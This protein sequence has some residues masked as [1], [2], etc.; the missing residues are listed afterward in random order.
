[1]SIRYDYLESLEKGD[2]SV[3]PPAVYVRGFIR[4]YAGFLGMDAQQLVRIYNHELSYMLED[5][6]KVKQKKQKDDSGWKARLSIT[7]HILTLACSFC[8]IAVLGYYFMHQINSFNSKPYLFIESPSANGVV[9]EKE[10]WISG[11][12]EE[13]AVLRINGQEISVGAGG[14][15]KEK[16]TLAEGRNTLVV[17]AENRF[18][19]IERREINIIYEAPPQEKVLVKEL[20]DKDARTA[21]GL[22]FVEE[23]PADSPAKDALG[24]VLGANA[25]AA[26]V[27]GT[28]AGEDGS[29]AAAKEKNETVEQ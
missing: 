21:D 4:S 23:I 24:S 6:K 20:P 14:N 9:R 7:P 26:T 15:F 17:E 25:S 11:N 5:D 1:V 3:L 22:E 8:V 29:E 18:S 27:E 2:Y 19:R 12:T 13:D 16:V 28:A 10:L